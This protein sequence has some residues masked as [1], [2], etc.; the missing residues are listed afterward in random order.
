MV[1]P[2]VIY[3][4]AL[5]LVLQNDLVKKGVIK[6]NGEVVGCTRGQSTLNPKTKGTKESY[7]KSS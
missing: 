7:W 5:M 4:L 6:P 2:E 3:Q 1:N